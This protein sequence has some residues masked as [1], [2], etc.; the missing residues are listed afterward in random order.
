MPYSFY[1]NS[2]SKSGWKDE[3]REWHQNGM[4]WLAYTGTHWRHFFF[5]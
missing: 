3:R 2:L 5:G 1:Y 4:M